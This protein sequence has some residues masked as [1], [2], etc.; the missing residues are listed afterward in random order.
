ML[1]WVQCNRRARRSRRSESERWKQRPDD[2]TRPCAKER[3]PLPGAG[4]AEGGLPS[5][6]ER[7]RSHAGTS[8]LVPRGQVRTSYLQS[9]KTINRCSFKALNLWSF[10]QQ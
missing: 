2:A 10:L 1:G 3:R 6:P 4:V 5:S 7:G 8:V 9:C